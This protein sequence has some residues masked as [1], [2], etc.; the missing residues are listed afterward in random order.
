MY[1]F[2]HLPFKRKSNLIEWGG[3]TYRGKVKEMSPTLK[4]YRYT[5]EVS[6]ECLSCF[7]PRA[8]EGKK[9]AFQFLLKG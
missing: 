5:T 7:Y 6:Y 2:L 4:V 8:Y 9:G 1:V 3:A